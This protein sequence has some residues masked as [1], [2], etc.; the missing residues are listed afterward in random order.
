M[1]IITDALRK[2]EEERWKTKQT[3]EKVLVQADFEQAELLKRFGYAKPEIV[4]EEA[5]A[6]SKPLRIKVPKNVFVSLLQKI[7]VAFSL[8]FVCFLV[9]YLGPRWLINPGSFSEDWAILKSTVVSKINS[10]VP[11]SF[12][13]ETPSVAS[14]KG[15]FFMPFQTEVKK[16]EVPVSVPIAVEETIQGTQPVSIPGVNVSVPVVNIPAP[17]VVKEPE[18]TYV[19][20]GISV[21]G[22]DHYAVVNGSI[23]QKG[24]SIDGAYVKDVLD[25]EVVLETRTAEI[26]LKLPT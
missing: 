21:T 7:F 3:V 12:T 8:I 2:A 17:V 16:E 23:V 15:I 25:R 14:G 20:S 22:G 26:K 1:S 5:T 24:D 11:G 6:S 18:P 9:V 13:Q 4:Q 10:L 19:L